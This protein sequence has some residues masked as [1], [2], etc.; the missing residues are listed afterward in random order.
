MHCFG[1][2]IESVPQVTTSEVKTG[3]LLIET[4]RKLFNPQNDGHLDQ[5]WVAISY[6]SGS[7]RISHFCQSDHTQKM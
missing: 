1:N 4:F 6:M 5:I 7:V 3:L 2:P